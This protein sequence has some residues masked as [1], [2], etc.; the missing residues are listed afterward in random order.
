MKNATYVDQCDT[1]R[2]LTE[3]EMADVSGG[4]GRSGGH[5]P[6]SYWTRAVKH[7]LP[8]D[9]IDLIFKHHARQASHQGS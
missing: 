6:P 4:S 2:I 7:L 9:P 5:L 1:I 3:E 8:V